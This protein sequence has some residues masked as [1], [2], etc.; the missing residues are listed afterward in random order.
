[1]SASNSILSYSTY[2]D[3]VRES[4]KKIGL[5]PRDYGTHSGCAGGAS[6]LAPHITEHELLVSGHWK[7]ARSICS[8]VQ[9][10][11][12]NRLKTNKVLQSFL[13]G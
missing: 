3:I 1:M 5:D 13:E 12:E 10:T 8:Y 11:D 2:R 9:L 4:I 7:D 6:S